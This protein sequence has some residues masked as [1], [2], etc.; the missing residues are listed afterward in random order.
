MRT[1]FTLILIISLSVP[2]FASNLWDDQ[3]EQIPKD[4][5][6]ELQFYA[7][8]ISQAVC[9]NIFAENQFLKG[10]TV[11][12][13]FGGNTTNTFDSQTLYFEQ[14][15]IPFIIYQPRIFN[16]MALLRASFEID[17]TWGD[18]AY[19]A[20]GNF[21]GG[22]AGDQVNFQTQ[23]VELELIPKEGWA[24]N[25]GLQRLFDTPYNQYRTFFNTMTTTGYRL[26]FWGSDAVGINVRHDSDFERFKV[27]YYQLYENNIQ[28]KDDV[29]FWEA[30]YERDL[31]PSWRQGVSLWYLHDRASGEGG[32]SILGQG[33]NSLLNDYNGTFRFLFGEKPYKADIAWIGT[34]WSKN[35]E[36]TLDRFGMSGFVIA[37]IGSID[38]QEEGSWKKGADVLGFAANFRTGYKYGQTT[39]DKVTADL[40]FTSGDEDGLDDDDYNG[41]I[42]GN[43]WGSPG[44]IF[45]SHGSYLLCCSH[46]LDSH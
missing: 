2:C 24:I 23:N 39:Q 10:Q 4:P 35:P 3:E 15:L 14:R 41:I 7:Y 27:G 43:T 22:F 12:R 31:S 29:T 34:Y 33:L 42:T 45:I 20:G 21:G 13:L 5:P 19:G 1:L 11:G 6:E 18:A 9:N 30:M 44:A 17:W 36:F 32:V 38:V 8:F 16:G 40:I 37:N 46:Q 26:A 25:L 28:E